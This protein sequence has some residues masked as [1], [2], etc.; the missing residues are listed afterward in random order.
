MFQNEFD[1]QLVQHL[2]ALMNFDDVSVTSKLNLTEF[3]SV[4][5]FVDQMLACISNNPALML[6]I[7]DVVAL[8]E[9]ERRSVIP[10]P[11]IEMDSDP[12]A[13]I[14]KAVG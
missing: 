13:T 10:I 8:P 12:Q 4:T 3:H 5:Q 2:L 9:V 7:S 14:R 11:T 1:S 6:F